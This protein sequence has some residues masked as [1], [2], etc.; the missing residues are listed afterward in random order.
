[1]RARPDRRPPP[2]S[3]HALR[4]LQASCCHCTMALLPLLILTTLLLSGGVLLPSIGLLILLRSFVKV[5]Q[6]AKLDAPCSNQ[7]QRLVQSGWGVPPVV[8]DDHSARP[9]AACQV[10]R[11]DMPRD[12]SDIVRVAI[13]DHRRVLVE[14]GHL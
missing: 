6:R 7:R 2:L 8:H 12:R 11:I 4:K 1:M 14:L 5:R 13:G 3:K 9:N 10:S